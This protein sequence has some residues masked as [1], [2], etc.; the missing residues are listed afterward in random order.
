LADVASQPSSRSEVRRR[1]R[2]LPRDRRKDIAAA[3]SE[4]RAV[5]DPRDAPL[6]A[7]LAERRA[8]G[9]AR[10]PS[11]LL[12]L[13]R[14][15][16]GWRA[17][18]W[19]FHLTW[20]LAATRYAYYQLLQGSSGMWH[21]FLVGFLIY[22]LLTLPL[23]VRTISRTLRSSWNAPEAAKKNRELTH[24]YFPADTPSP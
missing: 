1:L 20:V 24:S 2:Q 18:A 11:W 8:A 4:G 22:C 13:A 7:A 17:W 21:W 5:R 16:Q 14:R 6:A 9:A 19:L 12:P 3:V 10:Y 15:P 23:T